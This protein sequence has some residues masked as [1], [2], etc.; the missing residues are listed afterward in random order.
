[1]AHV[2]DRQND[3]KTYLKR[4]SR[5][6]RSRFTSR[7]VPYI[8]P[9]RA[10][11]TQVLANDH[12]RNMVKQ[13]QAW[14]T[15][16]KR[17]N[18]IINR[19]NLSN[20]Q[21][22]AFDL[23]RVNIVRGKGLFCKSLMRAQLASVHFSAVYASLISVM[24]TRIPEV[25]ELMLYR[26]VVQLKKGYGENEKHL[27]S[28][29]L[30]LLAHLFT[31]QVI[32]ELPLLEFL[33]MCLIN[34]SNTSV[35]LAVL[36]LEECGQ[37]MVEKAPRA[38]EMVYSRLREILHNTQVDYRTQVLVDNVMEL[39]RKTTDNSATLPPE[40]DLVDDDDV[41]LHSLSIDDNVETLEELNLFSF[42]KYFDDNESKY[43]A[44][45]SV[46]LGDKASEKLSFDA[47][48]EDGPKEV[49]EPEAAKLRTSSDTL[50]GKEQKPV[51]V[52]DDKT[53]TDLVD[54]RR[55]VYLKIMS[56][57]SFEECAHKLLKFMKSYGGMESELCNMVIECCSQEKSFLRYYG[58]LA[59]RLCLV[60][61]AYVSSFEEQFANIYGSIHRYDTRKIR[62]MSTLFAFMLS[63]EAL[64]WGLM[65][66]VRLAE[67]ETTASSRIF[68]KIL[69]QEMAK[70]LGEKRM[71][72]FFRGENLSMAFPFADTKSTRFAINFFVQI[73]LGFVTEELRDRLKAS[74]RT[75]SKVETKNVERNEEASTSSSSS[76]MSS[77][78][79]SS[80]SGISDKN[81][82]ELIES[83]KRV[84]GDD[85]ESVPNRH[86]I[87][88]TD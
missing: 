23:L 30:R 41:I 67:D 51:L 68:L 9:V 14:I 22:C 10:A 84:L 62:N 25:T 88:R 18:G 1:M 48:S 77:S 61:K 2:E 64:N 32:D 27:C 82:I 17:I 24:N 6:L 50:A 80:S 13:Q 12:E 33:S 83:R 5:R 72:E 63:T 85:S 87:Q 69:F 29:S 81:E 20:V 76:S 59:Q 56:A 52:T 58:L 45:R 86:K 57:A 21:E 36:V 65:S 75:S 8:P 55:L 49:L 53:E 46:L 19:I 28:A 31:Q 38:T 47:E 71:R 7:F 11:R 37:F 54:F 26:L 39:R 74:T 16:K 66:I 73:E 60:S 40:L 70:T 42:D 34:P 79:L 78:S 3:E 15:L 35:E 43:A 4:P 44:I